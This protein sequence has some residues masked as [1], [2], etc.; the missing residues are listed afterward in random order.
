MNRLA[1]LELYEKLVALHG[2]VDRKGDANPYTS[3]N[4]HMFSMLMKENTLALRLPDAERAAF[5][6]RYD[7]T[8]CVQY[9]HQMPEYVVVPDSLLANVSELAPHFE[10][11]YAYMAAKKPKPTTK[12]KPAVKAKP[13]AK[14]KAGVKA[15]PILKKKARSKRKAAKKR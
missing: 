14:K 3:L 1:A 15:K 13:A 4:G 9:G 6:R 5:L 2:R 7:T 12:K 11:S 8:I 10:I